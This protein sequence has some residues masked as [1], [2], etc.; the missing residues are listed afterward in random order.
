MG[1]NGLCVSP[2]SK[3]QDQREDLCVLVPI[4]CTSVDSVRLTF[5]HFCG[6]VCLFV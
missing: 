1:P 3:G 4:F 6:A 5:P 2:I